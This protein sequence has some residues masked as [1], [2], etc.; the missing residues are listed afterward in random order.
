MLNEA[1]MNKTGFRIAGEDYVPRPVNR[2]ELKMTIS[3]VLDRGSTDP[4][5]TVLS[6]WDAESISFFCFSRS[7]V[8][9]VKK[10]EKVMKSL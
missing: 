4:L 3:T 2:R 9:G 5:S 1:R 6:I 8:S 7:K 10:K